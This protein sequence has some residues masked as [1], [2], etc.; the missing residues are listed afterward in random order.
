MVWKEPGFLV[1]NPH[2]GSKC[3]GNSPVDAESLWRGVS[4]GAGTS[5][6]SSSAASVLRASQHLRSSQQQPVITSMLS[7]ATEQH[8]SHLTTS[9]SPR[10]PFSPFTRRGG[11]PPPLPCPYPAIPGTRFLPPCTTVSAGDQMH[12][13]LK[14][15][16]SSLGSL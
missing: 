16:L 4:G 8:P 6:I 15:S 2:V 12:L 7:G 14:M 5:G 1:P 11:V 9:A 13:S 10:S 3:C